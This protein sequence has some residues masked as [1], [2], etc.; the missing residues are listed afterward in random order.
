VAAVHRYPNFLQVAVTAPKNYNE[1]SA[2]Q[3]CPESYLVNG[4][5]AFGNSG[6]AVKVD[7]R[8]DAYVT[9][10]NF[11]D[12][13]GNHFTR[14]ETIDGGIAFTPVFL[15]RQSSLDGRLEYRVAEPRVYIGAGYLQTADNYGYPHLSGLGFGVEKLPDLRSGLSLAGSAFFYPNATGNYTVAGP[16]SPNFG[17]TFRQAYDILK[18]DVGLALDFGHSPVYIQGGFSGDH[19]IAKQNAPIGQTHDGPYAGL[20]LKF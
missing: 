18:F 16:T 20:G 4:A 10:D 12:T 8:Q 7:Y 13:S 9:N 19:Y 15:A 14:F 17:R 6:F 2:G 1:F 5:Y 3:Y 11:V